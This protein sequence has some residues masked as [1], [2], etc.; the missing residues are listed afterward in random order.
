VATSGFGALL[1]SPNETYKVSALVSAD[2]RFVARTVEPVERF[3]ALASRFV[4]AAAASG[5]PSGLYRG[6]TLEGFENYT[7]YARSPLT[8]WSA[9]VALGSDYI[10]GPGRR[11]LASIGLAALISLLLAALLTWFA[12]RQVGEGRR[13]AARFE[14]SQKLEALGRLTGGIAHDFNNLLTP[15]VGALD[16]LARRADID[17]R[18]KRLALGALASAERA[19]KLTAQLLAFSRRQKLNV[20]P[21]DVGAMLDDM[22]SL[23]DQ[24]TGGSHPLDIVRP[25]GMVCAYSDLNQLE[26][27]ILNLVL[28]ARD[29]SREGTPIRIVLEVAGQGEGARTLIRVIDQ[30]S[31]MS[32]EVRRRALEP[33]FTTKSSGRGTGLGL[34]QVFGVVEQSG[35]SVDIA[36]APGEGTTVTITLRG[37]DPGEVRRPAEAQLGAG[38]V[39]ERKLRLLVVDDDHAVR[40]TIARPLEEA[41]HCV[42]SVSS[43]TIALA[44]L[45]EE[46]FDLVL[47]DFAM[48]RMDGA[49]LIRR[50]RALRPETRFL[51]ITGYSDSDAVAEAAPDVPIV[52]KPFH[53]EDLLVRVRAL[54]G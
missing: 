10:D 46:P 29:A 25:E 40:A 2:G 47:V 39:P 36:T 23:I 27:A 6:V 49:E 32:E 43:G 3:A 53:A 1:P 41:G 42:D 54:A 5:E 13:I 12:I 9:H 44:A 45:E 31:G 14:Q 21:I 22:A 33:F 11:F 28:N 35:G 24:S 17:A 15:I 37:C 30:G 51:M 18:G 48:P 50:A 20:E 52:K 34:A 7:A 16:I 26:L 8:Q 38:E 4:R 19:A